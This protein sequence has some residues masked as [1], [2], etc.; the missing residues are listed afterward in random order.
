V[1]ATFY[2]AA[3]VGTRRNPHIRGALYAR[4]LRRGEWPR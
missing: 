3:I 2:M 1:R 4:L